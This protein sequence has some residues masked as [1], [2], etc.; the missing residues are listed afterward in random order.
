MKKNNKSLLTKLNLKGLQIAPEQIYGSISLVPL[1]RDRVRYDLRL[2]GQKYEQDATI[3]S[4]DRDLAYMS[5]I[6][7]GLILQWGDRDNAL[8]NLGSSL[9]KPEGQTLHCGSVNIKLMHGMTKK[10]GKNQLRF[11]PLHLAMEGFLSLHFGGPSIAWRKYYSDFFLRRGLGW[12]EE[13]SYG[14]KSIVGLEEALR[15]FEIHDRQVGTILFAAGAI[16]GI[17]IVPTPEDYRLL[18]YSLLE[19]FYGELIYEY[20]NL[21]QN[22]NFPMSLSIDDNKVQD[23]TSLKQEIVRMRNDWASF[24]RDMALE[25]FD[26]ALDSKRVYTA[27]SF[28]L[29]KFL[30]DLNGDRD[31]HIGE[32]IVR[33]NGEIEYLKTYR[34][35]AAQTRRIILLDR[36]AKHNWDLEAAAESFRL[37]LLDFVKRLEKAGWGYLLNKNLTNS[38]H[39]T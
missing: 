26:R 21:Y 16:A 22:T 30:T 20:A 4:L 2:F 32:A 11:L 19:D 7:Q 23:L 14:G 8:V 31:N 37:S 24:H 3:V 5:Y 6:P 28:I 18:H 10:H 27:G 34:L 17:F 25:L 35:S 9:I 36:L 12:R 13:W 33:D 1:L 29:Q 38:R 39:Q 15:I